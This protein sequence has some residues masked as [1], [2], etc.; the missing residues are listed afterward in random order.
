MQIIYLTD[1]F[2][3]IEDLY[4]TLMTV[5]AR[6][7]VVSVNFGRFLIKCI[8]T[9]FILIVSTFKGKN[10]PSGEPILSFDMW[11]FLDVVSSTL[12]QTL[13]AKNYF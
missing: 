13:P 8:L 7:V 9:L 5:N 3:Q 11:H 6:L 2:D 4:V 1:I 10:M 12:K